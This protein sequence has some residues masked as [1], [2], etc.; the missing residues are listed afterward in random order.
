M[1]ESMGPE[2]GTSKDR[3]LTLWTRVGSYAAYPIK[4]V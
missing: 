3:G 1:S 4:N 2:S